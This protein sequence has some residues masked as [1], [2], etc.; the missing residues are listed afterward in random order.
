MVQGLYLIS[1]LVL[2]SVANAL[3][4]RLPKGK[5]WHTGRSECDSCA[6]QLRWQDLVPAISYVVLRGKCRYCKSPIPFRN[7]A[8]EIFLGVG[9]LMINQGVHNFMSQ[10]IIAGMLFLTTVIAVMDW[11]TKLVS[12]LMVLLLGGLIF[13]QQS[14]IGFGL[15]NSL[16]GTGIAIVIIGGI[17]AVSKGKAMGF[18]DV[19]IAA[20]IGW[21]LGWQDLLAALWVAFVTGAIWGLFQVTNKRAKLKSEMAFG[22]FLILGFWTA[23]VWGE[24]IWK[25]W[26]L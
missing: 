2:G 8:V 9:F 14:N 18:G 15:I 20:V 13:A 21:G 3:I 12:E 1:G 5:S 19:E 22:P 7:L 25:I 26:G 10:V 23:F 4:D 11:E 16:L 6:H 24:Q 17:W